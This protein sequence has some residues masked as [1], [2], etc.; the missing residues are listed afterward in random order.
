[1]NDKNLEKCILSFTA[2]LWNLIKISLLIATIFL[3]CHT[4]RSNESRNHV[5]VYDKVYK[6]SG[7]FLQRYYLY[8]FQLTDE[9][10]FWG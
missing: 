4:W 9:K 10:L 2:P 8:C 6:S 5:T 7:S 1:M 3:R